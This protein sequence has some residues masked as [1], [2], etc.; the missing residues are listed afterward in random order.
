MKKVV[1]VIAIIVAIMLV[2]GI[3]YTIHA[4]WGI[5]KIDETNIYSGVNEISKV[6]DNDGKVID[7][8]Y[9]S[10]GKREIIKYSEIP[11]DMVNAI[12]AVEDKKFW[13]HHGFNFIRTIGAI[14]D[15]IFNG[16]RISG[17]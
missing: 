13:K 15:S 5:K 7:S 11:E 12:V 10:E 1:K 2:I 17:T 9:F 8:L 4:L 6:Y 16:G 14:K 3:V